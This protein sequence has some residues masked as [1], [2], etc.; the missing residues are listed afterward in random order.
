MPLETPQLL[1]PLAHAVAQ[2]AKDKICP[3]ACWAARPA[4]GAGTRLRSR[5]HS[6]CLI[7]L[8]ARKKKDDDNHENDDYDDDGDDD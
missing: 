4:R 7:H 8:Q 1:A 6:G 3:A 2:H 5:L